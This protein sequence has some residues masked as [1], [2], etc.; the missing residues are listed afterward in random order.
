MEAMKNNRP[1]ISPSLI[2]L[3]VLLVSPLLVQAQSRTDLMTSAAAA[4]SNDEAQNHPK[5][6]GVATKPILECVLVAPPIIADDMNL[7][8]VPMPFTLTVTV[9]NTGD[10]LTDSV[11]ARV[12]LPKDLELAVPDI[13]NRHTKHIIPSRL[14]ATQSGSA[15]WQVKHPN[16]DVE[17][18]YVVTV[19][20]K[21]KNADSS[22]CEI[23]VTIPPLD[24]PIL[25]PRCYVPASLYFDD[26]LDT[27]VPNP[28][29]L[30]LTCVN[31]GNT[32]VSNVE[33]TI[34][35]PPDMEFDPPEQTATRMFTPSSMDKYIPPTPAPELIWTVRWT[36]RY[37]KDTTAQIRWTVTGRRFTGAQMDSTEV[38][39][40][41]ASIPG[42]RPRYSCTG[43]TCPD[44]L[45]VNAAGTDVVPNPFTVRR[46]ITNI[47]KQTG[48]IVR[49]YISFPP[50]GL[51]LDPSSPDPQDQTMDL[52][53][54]KGE[55]RTFEWIIRVQN[56]LTRRLPL[57]TMDLITDEGYTM[58][59]E[60]Y[61]PIANVRTLTGGDLLPL[62][63][64]TQLRQ[65]HPNPF[66]PTTTITYTLGI[67]SEYTLTLFDALGRKLK[68]L[69]AGQKSAGSYTYAL[70]ATSLPSGVYLYRLE[71][72]SFSDTKRMILSR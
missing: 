64:T 42:L 53:L 25:A 15:T 11:W 46:T 41:I 36:K 54:E 51:S 10:M 31:T 7:R 48:G 62:P 49:S 32:K 63:F 56:R 60:R 21:T 69:D 58:P 38:R 17:K 2:L 29:P 27:Y 3:L 24:W 43:H 40:S 12:I 5:G 37:R 6:A 18:N 59:C 39:C 19:W 22:K 20:V 68:V 34:I 67:T 23:M 57:I 71:T 28:I 72:A 35:L 13:P 65:N 14:F 55:S 16:T 4:G 70:D 50:D 66:N 61:L 30:R 45:G 33:G 52:V 9:T 44:S 1:L 47:S 26:T 8:Y